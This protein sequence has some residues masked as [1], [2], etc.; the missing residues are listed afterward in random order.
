MDATQLIGQASSLGY[1]VPYPILVFFK[2][3]GFT[4]HLGPMHLFF[5]GILLAMGMH[6]W[7]GVQGKLWSKRL[8][9]QMPIIISLGVNFGIVPLLFMQVAYYRLFYPATIFMAWPWLMI[10]AILIV[11]YYGV[12]Y[13]ASGLRAGKLHKS[14]RSLGWIAAL[15]FL[16][17]GFLFSSGLSLLTNVDSWPELFAKSNYAGAVL[18]TAMNHSEPTLLPRWLM[19]FGLALLTVAVYAV[20]DGW[21]FAG[22][23]SKEYRTWVPGFALKV[24]TTGLIWYAVCGAWYV[25]SA[26]PVV[27][28]DYLLG[29]MLIATVLTAALPVLAWLLI[30][31]QRK[32]LSFALALLTVLVQFLGLAMQAIT[33][34]FVQNVE[35]ARYLDVASEPLNP[36]WDVFILFL[37]L[38]VAGLGL[39]FWMIMQCVFAN[40][41]QAAKKAH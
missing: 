37:V 29:P 5:A 25:F 15:G 39:V 24:G 34:Q 10:V 1:P 22:K 28:K 18:G 21:F 20:M 36:Q 6:K 17:M 30:L 11:S 40:R 7:G 33:R 16:I 27:A 26:M 19:M 31:M 9:N 13:Y 23:E 38:F 35:A 4:L 2:I 14:H 3:L 8:M 12:Y 32:G 41:E